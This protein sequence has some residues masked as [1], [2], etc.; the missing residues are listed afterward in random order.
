MKEKCEYDGTFDNGSKKVIINSYYG[1]PTQTELDEKLKKLHDIM[2]KVFAYFSI[3][4]FKESDIY[5]MNKEE[6]IKVM[7]ELPDRP[8]PKVESADKDYT[9]AMELIKAYSNFR[10]SNLISKTEQV[11]D[12]DTLADELCTNRNSCINK[13]YCIITSGPK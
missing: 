3:T 10:M 9:V 2:V 12:T 6:T 8:F 7:E 5:K 13:T 11:N 4:E 1:N